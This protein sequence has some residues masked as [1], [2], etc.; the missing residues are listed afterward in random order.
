MA[1]LREGCI[2]L[3]SP[4]S[5]GYN[6]KHSPKKFSGKIINFAEVNQ[7][8]W[9]EDSGQW[10]ENVDR[11]HLVLAS[12]KPVLQKMAKQHGQVIT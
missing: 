3:V 7:W 1:K 11:T 5:P 2:A 4:S 9:L 8:C 6:S 10:L 12:G